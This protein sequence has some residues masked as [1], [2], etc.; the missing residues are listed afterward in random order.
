MIFDNIYVVWGQDPL[1]KQYIENH[2]A[3]CGIDNYKFVRSLV[4]KDFF[5]NKNERFKFTREEWILHQCKRQGDHMPMSLGEVGCAYG[6][7]KAYKTAITDGAEKFLVVEDDVRFDVDMCHD[8]LN[9]KE[10]IP[11]DWDIIHYHSW[12]KYKNNIHLTDDK[13][14]KNRKR[15]NKYFY[16]GHVE[17]AGAVCYALTSNIAKQLLSRFYPIQVAADG[18]IALFSTTKFAR[19]H[20]SAYVIKPFLVDRTMFKSQIDEEV[21][22]SVK[23]KTRKQRYKRHSQ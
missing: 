8:V 4:P 20:Y 21:S 11:I 3:K 23:Y 22:S 13:L 12:R 15:I 5:Y 6:H 2:F 9:W 14:A 7:L 17:F 19:E 10:Y 1:K 18:A 16:S